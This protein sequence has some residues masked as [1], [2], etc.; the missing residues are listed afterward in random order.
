MGG[1]QATQRFARLFMLPSVYHCG[2]GFG[3]S[4]FDMTTRS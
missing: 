2:G 4:Q 1:L 3:P